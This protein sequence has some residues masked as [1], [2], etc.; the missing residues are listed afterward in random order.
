MSAITTDVRISVAS[1]GLH[2]GLESQLALDRIGD[3]ERR[4]G[5]LRLEI[6]RGLYVA[7]GTFA[8][9][10]VRLGPLLLGGEVLMGVRWL[11]LHLDVYQPS[12]RS[13]STTSIWQPLVQPRVTAELQ[14]SPWITAGVHA[15]TDVLRDGDT[16][17]GFFVELHVRAFDASLPR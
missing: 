7:A 14:L 1:R 13:S 6:D 9:V 15:A 16:A 3:E 8:G 11:Q 17:V 4:A 2:A 5:D 10:G 12:R